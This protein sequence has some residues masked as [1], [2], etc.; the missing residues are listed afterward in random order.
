MNSDLIALL[1]AALEQKLDTV[2]TEWDERP[3]LGVVLAAGGYPG[4]YGKGDVITGLPSLDNPA[5]DDAA[6]KIFHAGTQM[7]DG[8]VKTNGGRV[9]CACAL[10]DTIAE[11]QQQAYQRV[12]QISWDN[13]YYRTDIGYRAIERDMD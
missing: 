11:A 9:L 8:Q 5:S 13:I 6:S 1:L 10:G 2:E 3:A 4:A 7:I 12:Q